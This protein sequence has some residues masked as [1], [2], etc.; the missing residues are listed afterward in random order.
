MKTLMTSILLMGSL[1][2]AD[3]SGPTIGLKDFRAFYYSLISVTGV[4]PTQEIKAYFKSVMTRLPK[5][6]RV[7]EMS[8]SMLLAAKGISAIFCREF[9]KTYSGRHV[10][11]SESLM[12]QDLSQRF[13]NRRLGE[14]ESK[15]LLRSF[16]SISHKV[17]RV[18]LACTAMTSSIEFLVQ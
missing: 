16:R 13:Y 5:D 15:I 4:K 8:S 2:M 7:E 9:S 17:D 14:P 12:L 3:V 10:A 6:G 1:V 11:G 18:F